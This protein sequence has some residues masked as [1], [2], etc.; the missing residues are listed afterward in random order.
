M[1]T[2][3]LLAVDTGPVDNLMRAFIFP[4][5]IPV[6]VNYRTR[7]FPVVTFTIMGICSA[8]HLFVMFNFFS[9]GYEADIELAMDIGYV[10]GAPRWYAVLTHMFTHADIFHLIGNMIYLYLFGSC[11]EDLLGRWKYIVFYLLGGF[12]ALGVYALFAPS[13]TSPDDMIPL[14]GAS[15][16]ISACMGGFLVVLHHREITIKWIVIFFFKIY[17]GDWHLQAKL[18]MSF[19]FAMDLWGMISSAGEGGGGVAFSAH[20]GG[21]LGGAA[22]MWFAKVTKNV[23]PDPDQ[24]ETD[25]EEVEEIP[26]SARRKPTVYLLINNEQTGPYTKAQVLEMVQ[27]GT[28]DHNTLFWEQGMDDWRTLDYM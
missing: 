26:V 7:Q 16:A 18:V 1:G 20:V 4:F 13:P 17:S 3:G 12:I 14:V 22:M 11:V 27:I 5:F 9:G 21:F 28:I 6:G 8:V 2:A 19:W 25:E 10:V 23:R 15:G 24:E